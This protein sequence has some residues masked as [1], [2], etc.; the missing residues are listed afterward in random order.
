MAAY[1][2]G[3]PGSGKTA[4]RPVLAE[5]LP[6]RIIVD[7]DAFM[8]PASA[9]AGADVRT[10]PATWPAYRELVRAVV[11]AAGA[12]RCV[13]LGVCT[14]E[15]LAG[16]PIHRW[17]VLDCDADER[18]RRLEGRS[19]DLVD[20]LEDAAAYRALRLPTIDTT[21]RDLAQI[22]ALVADHLRAPFTSS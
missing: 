8:T 4:L 11:E 21:G 12:D 19:G 6:D 14:P 13:V 5:L 22:A 3:A 1:V 7:W 15:E 20:A 9:L 16:W 10:A 17:L 18:E 2:L